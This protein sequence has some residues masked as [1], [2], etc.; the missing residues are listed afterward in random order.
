MGPLIAKVLEEGDRELRKE[1]AAR[2]RAEE[3]LHGMNELTDI[4]LHL[5]EKIWAFRC[6]NHQTPEDTSQQQ[7]A[8]L[9]S[10]LDSALAQLELQSVQIEYEQLRRENDQ[11]RAPNNWQFEK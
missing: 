4:L 9:E 7:R 2:H 8:T 3:E 5:I 1:R 6:T 11:L 10:I